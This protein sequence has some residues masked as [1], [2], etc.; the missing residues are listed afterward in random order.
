MKTTDKPIIVEETFNASIETVW[1]SITNIEQ[2]RK[3]YFDNIPSFK[4]EVGFVTQFN[5]QSEER[6]FLH[7]WKIIEVE[8]LKKINYSWEFEEYPGKSTA[9]FELT[10][11]NNL[12]KLTLTVEVQKN[13]PDNIPEFARESCIAGW[14]YFINNRLK[15]FLE[16]K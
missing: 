7:K 6:N 9:S 2:M 14:N 16:N 12:T 15:N 5:V 3:W 8:P 10:S 11:E 13:F 4:P 1:D